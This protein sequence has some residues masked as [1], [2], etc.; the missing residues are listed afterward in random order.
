MSKS[1]LAEFYKQTDNSIKFIDVS[2][3]KKRVTEQKAVKTVKEV[4]NE[5]QINGLNQCSKQQ[6]YGIA[7]VLK[8]KGLS[9]RQ[10]ERLTGISH[11]IAQK[12]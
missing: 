2:V 1:Q 8:Q 9:L 7:A 11:W 10:I 3:T 6:Q 5:Y 12:G 4:Y